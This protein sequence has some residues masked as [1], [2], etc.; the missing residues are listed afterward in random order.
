M[1]NRLL[2]RPPQDTSLNYF[3]KC[4]VTTINVQHDQ[5]QNIFLAIQIQ[6]TYFTS[7]HFDM[8]LLETALANCKE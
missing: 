6:T 3:N 2:I 1:V 4:L 7:A 5:I 8:A